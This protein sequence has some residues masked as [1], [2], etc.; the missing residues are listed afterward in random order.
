MACSRQTNDFLQAASKVLTKDNIAYIY[1]SPKQMESHMKYADLTLDRLKEMLN[2]DPATG[3]FT[4][5]IRPT[6]NSRM[7]PGDV[8]GCLKNRGYRYISIDSRT[9]LASQL[10]W[11]FVHGEWAPGE[12]GTTNKD[13]SDLRSDNLF[14]YHTPPGNHYTGTREGRA[15]YNK[16]RRL[17]RPGEHRS[18]GWKRYYNITSDDYQ[19]MFLEQGGVCDICKKPETAK[20]PGTGDTKWL[21]VDHN[22]TTKAVRSLLCSYC[23][24]TI[25]HASDDPA[26]LRAAADYL[27]KHQKANAAGP[28]L[29]IADKETG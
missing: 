29:V 8:A 4:W 15:A 22:H 11:A 26:V 20:S 23:N 12:V 5:K 7:H 6:R 2:Y 21:S 14:A 24:H 18:Y 10:A 25:G 27:E 17:A 3:V 9:Y 16:A 13:P 19:R 1:S 28:R